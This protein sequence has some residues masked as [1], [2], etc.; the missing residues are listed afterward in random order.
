MWTQLPSLLAKRKNTTQPFADLL[1]R[2][3]TIDLGKSVP[4]KLACIFAALLDVDWSLGDFLYFTFQMKDKDET[5]LKHSSQHAMY[6][7]NFLQGR[8]NYMILDS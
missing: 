7:R 8:T 3:E 1:P 6:A 4:E 5:D 2:N